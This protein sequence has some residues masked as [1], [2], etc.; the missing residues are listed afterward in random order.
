[1]IHVYVMH[2]SAD[3]T[4][5]AEE[6]CEEIS[7]NLGHEIMPVDLEHLE[8]V[9]NIAPGKSIYCASFRL[10]PEVM[11]ADLPLPRTGNSEMLMRRENWMRWIQD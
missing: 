9:R 11:F 3:S 4:V 8:N 10:P 5:A 1:M 6:I 2:K 7:K